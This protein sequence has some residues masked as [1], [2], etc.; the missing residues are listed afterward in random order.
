MTIKTWSKSN[1]LVASHII[2]CKNEL[3]EIQR[4]LVHNHPMDDSMQELPN[5]II[6]C[7]GDQ[8]CKLQQQSRINWLTQGDKNIKFMKL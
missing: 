7:Y 5:R 8:E 6:S 3:Y 1:T 2:K 4:K